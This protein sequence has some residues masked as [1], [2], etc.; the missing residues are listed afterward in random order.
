M[1]KEKHFLG[2]SMRHII[3]MFTIYFGKVLPFLDNSLEKI[4]FA[5]FPNL[6]SFIKVWS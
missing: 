5:F 1:A 2:M 4:S 6:F 3:I